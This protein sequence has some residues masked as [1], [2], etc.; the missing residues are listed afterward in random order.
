[1]EI[2]VSRSLQSAE[3]LGLDAVDSSME[4]QQIERTG[5]CFVRETSRVGTA[6][7]SHRVVDSEWSGFLQVPAF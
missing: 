1:M 4:P 7:R 2:S 3:S 6:A 5:S